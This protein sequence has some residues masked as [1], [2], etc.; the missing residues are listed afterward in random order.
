VRDV[1]SR[2]PEPESA[3]VIVVSRFLQ[4]SLC[5]KL[6]DALRPNGVL[7][8]QTFTSGLSNPDYL[9]KENELPELFASLTPCYKFQSSVDSR[10]FSEAQFV[11]RKV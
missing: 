6:C 3:D 11:G 10:G 5:S 4:R 9:L 7:F 1:V 2:P 8:Y